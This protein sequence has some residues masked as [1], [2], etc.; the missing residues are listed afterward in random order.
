M[1]ERR[2][3]LSKKKDAIHRYLLWHTSLGSCE[4]IYLAE[5]PKS[6]GT[7][8]AQMLSEL[9]VLPF[10]R[11]TSVSTQPCILHGHHLVSSKH[12]K[13]IHLIR[14]GRDIMI[15][16]YHYFLLNENN[17]EKKSWKKRTGIKDL[18]D[19]KANLSL[20]I[21]LFFENYRSGL[22]NKKWPDFIDHYLSQKHVIQVKYESLNQDP[23]SELT[24][25]LKDLSL[26]ISNE[27]ITHAVKKYSFHSQSG[28]KNGDEN[29]TAFLRKGVVGDWKNYFNNDSAEIFNF[30]AGDALVTAGY[31]KDKN[32]WY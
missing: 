13:I 10:P 19:V 31:E 6:G 15:S 20:F 22:T 24:I 17:P 12:K 11:N 9:F 32:W 8:L 5:F 25:L 27:K 29:P 4:N 3:T 26:I 21:E 2:S 16:A 23:I 28:R 1:I 18:K 7:W 14:D 30:Y